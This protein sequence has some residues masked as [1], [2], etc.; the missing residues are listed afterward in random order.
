MI[1]RMACEADFE[2]WLPLWK[3]YQQFYKAD[4]SERTTANTWARFLDATEPM[5]CAVAEVDKNIVGARALH[6]APE[7]LDCWRLRLLARPFC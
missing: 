3:G 7:L 1:I 6:P 4:I 5:H 2:S